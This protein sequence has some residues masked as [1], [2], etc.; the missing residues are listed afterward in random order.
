MQA[1]SSLHLLIT[2]SNPSLGFCRTLLSAT[3]LGYPAPMLLRVNTTVD[4]ESDLTANAPDS[5]K[6]IAIHQYLQDRRVANENDYV[7][8][9]DGA[10]SW[11]QLPPDLMVERYEK[12]LQVLDNWYAPG[13]KIKD[14][15]AHRHSIL[16]A[17]SASCSSIMYR[18][19][20]DTGC[21]HSPGPPPAHLYEEAFGNTVFATK[22]AY[23]HA[24]ALIGTF[25]STRNFYSR[26]ASRL[27]RE[28]G[29]ATTSANLLTELLG[30]QE[31]ARQMAKQA[32]EASADDLLDWIQS[33]I[34]DGFRKPKNRSDEYRFFP[35][36][37]YEFG[38]G[39]DF[40]SSLF[41]VRDRGKSKIDFRRHNDSKVQGQIGKHHQSSY[42]SLPLDIASSSSP[43]PS[44]NVL[45]SFNKT[46]NILPGNLSWHDLSLASNSKLP[47]VPVLLQLSGEK[48]HNI[49]HMW[50][51]MWFFPWARAL[52]RNAYRSTGD[53]TAAHVAAPDT[54][55]EGHTKYGSG[56]A[57]TYTGEWKSWEQMCSGFDDEL[58][59]DRKGLWGKEADGR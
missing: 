11:F 42:I 3:I 46:L 14:A 13:N 24:G 34:V 33:K 45:S 58:F 50:R 38:L 32:L 2:D 27:Q 5:E 36:G 29:A 52:L 44:T 12:S 20:S 56:G 53:S 31:Y 39:L 8:I 1:N 15:A 18:G 6:V 9:I 21:K 54:K 28:D 49:E 26:A 40:I 25:S 57:W 37:K 22:A 7:L 19:A 47:S 16:F 41:H 17:P 43:L 30:E 55:L 59:G 4:T 23:L 51:K 48:R 35:E 10:D